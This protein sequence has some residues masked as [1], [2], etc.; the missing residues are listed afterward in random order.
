MSIFY[1]D[2]AL[3]IVDY[4]NDF[5]D[6]SLAVKD[7]VGILN[8]M[9]RMLEEHRWGL[10]I[11][12]QDWHPTNHCS[13]LIDGKSTSAKSK[14]P[15]HCI[16]GTHGAELFHG[17]EWNPYVHMIVRK[18][19]LPTYEAYSAFN[20]SG[21][22]R[23][24][25]LAELLHKK[26]VKEVYVCGLAFDICVAQTA[27]DAAFNHFRTFILRDLCRSVINKEIMFPTDRI[28]VTTS[29]ILEKL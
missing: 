29:G 18:G 12:T 9:I 21:D 15:P 20:D 27:F 28:K 19:C 4:Q 10:V 26:D 2:R 14:W 17:S 5:V 3:I 7:A 16:A 25:G 13:F 11:A 8:P 1:E 24:G 6:G 22:D 23:R